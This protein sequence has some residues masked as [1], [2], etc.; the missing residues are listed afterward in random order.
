ML[1]LKPTNNQRSFYGKAMVSFSSTGAKTL[2]S[3]GTPIAVIDHDGQF[4]KLWRG[5]SATTMKHI[6][7]FRETFGLSKFSKSEWEKL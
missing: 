4:I 1:E 7:S 5:Y 6:N 2:Y 3:Y